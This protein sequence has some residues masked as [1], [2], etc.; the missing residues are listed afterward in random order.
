M[1]VCL[2]A[3]LTGTPMHG[4]N[5]T[6]GDTQKPVP[7]ETHSKA[8]LRRQL[9][10]AENNHK[11]TQAKLDSKT[12]KLQEVKEQLR[13]KEK[14]ENARLKKENEDLNKK[15]EIYTPNSSASDKATPAA[16]DK[17]SDKAEEKKSIFPTE[18][19]TIGLLGLASVLASVTAAETVDQVQGNNNG[20]GNIN[21]DLSP[22]DKAKLKDQGELGGPNGQGSSASDDAQIPAPI[23]V[24]FANYRPGT[25]PERIQP[26]IVTFLNPEDATT[27]P[28]S[29][30]APAAPVEAPTQISQS[31]A[32]LAINYL[33]SE[34]NQLQQQRPSS[35]EELES[36]KEQLA[37]LRQAIREI[38]TLA[39]GKSLTTPGNEL[40]AP[41]PVETPASG[42]QQPQQTP[43]SSYQQPQTTLT[44]IQQPQQQYYVGPTT[45][46]QQ[47]SAP[48]YQQQP[49]VY[50][51]APQS[52]QQ[53]YYTDPATSYQQQAPT[54]TYQQ[55][56]PLPVQNSQQATPAS[57]YQQP[58]SAPAQSYQPAPN[59]ITPPPTT[60]PSESNSSSPLP[61]WL[62][63]NT[64][65]MPILAVQP[66]Q[67]SSSSPAGDD[68]ASTPRTNNYNNFLASLSDK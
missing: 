48:M 66:T 19:K 39:S 11:A 2:L 5:K 42:Y 29:Y 68:N 62:K 64:P 27:P 12:T 15:L 40:P 50:Q 47:P 10:Q 14:E 7:S 28:P 33:K 30:Q 22:E 45:P 53:Q 35:T 56:G 60:P 63:P 41:E 8:E 57:S 23:T 51:Q 65:V 36:I 58:I 24:T 43:A 3:I 67:Q 25:P 32:A 1:L 38:T 18:A 17:T 16:A 52:Y 61:S 4:M 21:I 6:S 20:P 31:D 44:P 9:E 54:Q 46:Y 13:T 49:A 37:D 55:Q 34:E 26:H 59:A